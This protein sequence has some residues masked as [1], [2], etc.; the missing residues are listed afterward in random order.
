MENC[1]SEGSILKCLLNRGEVYGEG[2]DAKIIKRREKLEEVYN[3]V[4][5]D[6]D[7]ESFRDKMIGEIEF[8]KSTKDQILKVISSLSLHASV[9]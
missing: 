4:F 6:S 5:V 1:E 2:E 7:K 3:T 9:E 8:S